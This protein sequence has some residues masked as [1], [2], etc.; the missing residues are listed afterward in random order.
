MQQSS[1][2]TAAQQ[3]LS[4][5]AG[6]PGGSSIMPTSKPN[7]GSRKWQRRSTRHSSKLQQVKLTLVLVSSGATPTLLQQPLWCSVTN[8]HRLHAGGGAA[9]QKQQTQQPQGQQGA[10]GY[11]ASY[12]DPSVPAG[13]AEYWQEWL[14]SSDSA[15]YWRHYGETASGSC[16]SLRLAARSVRGTDQC[17]SYL[18]CCSQAGVFASSRGHHKCSLTVWSRATLCLSASLLS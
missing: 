10:D 7:R 15:A 2:S 13:S 3:S 17:P 5:P 16:S 1:S 6:L 4:A 12:A 18:K 8:K 14:A 9:Q 11:T